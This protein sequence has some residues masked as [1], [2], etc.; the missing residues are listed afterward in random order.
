MVSA[1]SS[2][3]EDRQR[4]IAETSAFIAWGLRHPDKV[5]WIP[6]R[7]DGEGGFSQRVSLVFWTPVFADIVRRPASW[8][9]ALLRR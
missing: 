5:R 4:M 7:P 3:D 8:L 9:K 6:T 2:F 1:Y